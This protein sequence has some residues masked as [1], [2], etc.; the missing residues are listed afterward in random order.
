MNSKLL[1]Q[2]FL[3]ILIIM[4]FWRNANKETYK[5]KHIIPMFINLF[6]VLA[7]FHII[8]CI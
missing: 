7:F 6:E 3:L 5:A 2:I 1:C 8:D 4:R